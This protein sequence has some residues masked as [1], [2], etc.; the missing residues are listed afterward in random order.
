MKH[1]SMITHMLC[2]GSILTLKQWG[3]TYRTVI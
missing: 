2:A 3:K 1:E